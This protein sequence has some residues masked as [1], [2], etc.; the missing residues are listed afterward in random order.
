MHLV[1]HWSWGAVQKTNHQ[2]KK[3]S[4]TNSPALKKPFKNGCLKWKLPLPA[5]FIV[6][7]EASFLKSSVVNQVRKQDFMWTDFTTYEV[8]LQ[9]FLSINWLQTLGFKNRNRWRV[10]KT[11]R[12]FTYSLKMI[13]P[14]NLQVIYVAIVF[15]G[16]LVHQHAFGRF[17]SSTDSKKSYTKTTTFTLLKPRTKLQVLR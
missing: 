4:K 10:T 9:C 1:H 12:H 3:L 13:Q 11:S 7:W 17:D 8:S 2:R 14:A 16:R 6:V 5:R 15:L